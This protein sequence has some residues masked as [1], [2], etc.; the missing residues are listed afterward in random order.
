MSTPQ[1]A[2]PRA[3]LSIGDGIAMMVGLIIGVGIFKLPQLVALNTDS[4]TA[5]LG[6]WVL[7]GVITLIGAMV[8]A[9]LAAAYPSTG[10]EYHFLTRALGNDV[11]LLFAWARTTVIQTGAIAAVAFVFG[12]YAQQLWPLGAHGSPIYAA[13]ALI[14]LTLINLA[15]TYQSKTA[16]IVFTILE[17]GALL[18]VSLVGLALASPAP[19]ASAVPAASG[20]ALG[21]AI[22]FI[23][24]TYGGWNEAAYLSKDVRD[25][26]RNMVRILVAGTLAVTL[27]YLLINLAYLHILGLEGM[28]KSSAI[29][30]DVM[31]AGLGPAGAVLL[32]LFVCCAALSTINASIF[33]GARV[34]HA[35]GEDLAV[36]SLSFWSGTGNNPRNAIYLQSAIALALV[37]FGATTKEGFEAMVNYTAPVFWFFLFLVGVSSIVL[38]QREG[39]HARPFRMPLYPVTPVL[40]CLTCLYLLYSS[41]VYAGRG[42]LIGV[43]V[44]LLGVPLVWWGRVKRTA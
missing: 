24:F 18:F 42:A 12:D 10:G 26:H 40:F 23:L 41:L 5:F 2:T 11:G 19:I 7:G 38:R 39:G 21:L 36:R 30:A 15:G 29:A 32:S 35:L 27:L 33:T 28:R 4:I 37:A 8:Y 13:A 20:G 1:T 31:R 22:V 14:F 3:S 43:V 17:V 25:V 9:E 6:L 16:Q 34:Y 44:L